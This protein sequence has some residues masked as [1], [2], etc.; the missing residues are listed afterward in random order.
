MIDAWHSVGGSS[1]KSGDLGGRMGEGWVDEHV[2][3]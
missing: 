3:E 2:G 1:E